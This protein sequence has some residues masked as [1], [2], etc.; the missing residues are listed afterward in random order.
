MTP[1]LRLHDLSFAYPGE[2]PLISRLSLDIAP[3]EKVFLRGKNGAGKTTLFSLI[4]GLRRPTTG[5]IAVKGRSISTKEDFRYLRR[6]VGFLFQD[7]DDQLFCP[8]LLDDVLFG[9]LNLG[10]SRKDA[11]EKTMSVL[12]RLHIEELADVPPYALSGGQKRL[13]ALA[14]VLSMEP[15]LLLLDEPSSGLD[16]E[17]RET[18]AEMLRR[19][20]SSL[21]I[22]SHDAGFLHDVASS[23]YELSGGTL[24]VDQEHSL[25]L[26]TSSHPFSGCNGDGSVK[27]FSNI[28]P[29]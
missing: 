10:F 12:K 17:A 24:K 29:I 6:T 3:G 4:M 16:D 14:A 22:A 13:G 20:D 5:A 26:F 7:P 28:P 11:L 15:E 8:T 19:L 18:L 9:P 25:L 1:L 27:C 23:G 2:P 21:I